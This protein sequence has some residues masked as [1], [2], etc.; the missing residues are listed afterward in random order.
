MHP[1]A[2]G[3]AMAFLTGVLALALVLGMC[4]ATQT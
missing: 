1:L 2:R 3:L 4:V